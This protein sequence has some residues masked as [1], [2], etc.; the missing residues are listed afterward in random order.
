VHAEAS[1]R[2]QLEHVVG[3]CKIRHAHLPGI[4]PANFV[5]GLGVD[6]A[7]IQESATALVRIVEDG[8]DITCTSADGTNLVVRPGTRRWLARVGHVAPGESVT[9]PTG[10]ICITPEDVRGSFAATACV[11]R[12]GPPDRV[13]EAPIVFEIDGG[14]VTAVHSSGNPELV[15]DVNSILSVAANSERVGLVVL[16][17]NTGALNA[18]GAVEVDQH[19]PG[20]HLVIGDPLSRLSGA[21]WSARTSF[22]ACQTTSEV[23]VGGRL[24]AA[25]G[26]LLL[27]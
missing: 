20:L 21:G 8:A 24:L 14:I 23:H 3:A 25:E 10:S 2:Q 5:E 18:T 11:G 4:T 9:F 17:V 16:G 19:R 12:L 6:H 27:P 1:M 13:L 15:R 26:R 22:A 7:T